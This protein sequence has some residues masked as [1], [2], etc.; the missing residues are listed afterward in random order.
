MELNLDSGHHKKFLKLIYK[1]VSCKNLRMVELGFSN[2]SELKI[3]VDCWF[4][5]V[6]SVRGTLIGLR[7]KDFRDLELVEI[8]P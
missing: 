5:V 4:G 2:G 1:I 6:V 7:R 3:V 8:S